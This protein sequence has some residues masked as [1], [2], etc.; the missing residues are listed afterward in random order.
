MVIKKPPESESPES[1]AEIT[2]DADLWI[3][4]FVRQL[5]LNV[6]DAARKAARNATVSEL[7]AAAAR[8]ILATYV[9]SGMD[10][11]SVVE[12]LGQVALE[13]ERTDVAWSDQMNQRRFA[14]I[15]KENQ[16]SL[17]SAE[18]LELAGLT[19]IMRDHAESETN[20]PMTGA[21]ALHRKMLDN[22]SPD[23]SV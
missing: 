4:Q 21:R 22:D 23:E 15:D 18:R 10:L 1:H 6:L 14:L 16:G 17:S 3:R 5:E 2:P 20:L 8:A 11:E 12:L 19:R 13:W 9:E 7:Q